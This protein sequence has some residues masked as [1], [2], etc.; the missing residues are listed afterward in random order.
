MLPAMAEA[1]L[2]IDQYFTYRMGGYTHNMR[3]ASTMYMISCMKIERRP[4]PMKTP[5][6]V[7]TIQ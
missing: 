5:A 6:R 2:C 4:K 7:G 1:A 3:Y